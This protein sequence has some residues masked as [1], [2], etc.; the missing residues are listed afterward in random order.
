MRT[1]LFWLAFGALFHCFSEPPVQRAFPLRRQP[2]HDRLADPVVIALHGVAMAGTA[3]EPSRTQSL[4]H[5]PRRR[6]LHRVCG[7]LE[8]QRTR[9]DREHFEEHAS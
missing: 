9:R 7:Q 2:E 4:V 5:G 6:Q 3:H 1:E 8:R